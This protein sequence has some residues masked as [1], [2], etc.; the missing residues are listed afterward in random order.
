MDLKFVCIVTNWLKL[1][2]L[3][4]VEIPRFRIASN[5]EV[6]ENLAQVNFF[7]RK[8][9]IRKMLIL[10]IRLTLTEKGTKTYI[11][12]SIFHCACFAVFYLKL[13]SRLPKLEITL[14]NQN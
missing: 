7:L 5:S 8:C 3:F 10:T 6:D 1:Y 2:S 12:A 9:S 14:M 11:F 4:Q 13:F